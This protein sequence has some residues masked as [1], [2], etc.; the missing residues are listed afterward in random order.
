MNAP[1]DPLLV[2]ILG[3]TASSKTALA[4]ALA[5]QF[6][7]EIISCDSVSV[8]REANIGAAKP[9]AAERARIPHHM[10]DIASPAQRYTAGDYSRDARIAIREIAALNKLP[11]VS[12]GTGLYLRALLDGLFP[13]PQR[14]PALRERLKA[15]GES[16]DPAYIHR[17]LRRLDAQAA[18]SIHA[19]DTPKIIRAIEVSLTA[20]QP[21][22]EAWRQGRDPLTGFRILRIGLDP[23]RAQLYERINQRGA[24]M[25]A[26]GLV[27]ETSALISKYGEEIPVLSALG[28]KQARAFLRREIDE[29]ETIRQTQQG[30]RNYA[31]RQMSWFRREPGVHWLRG[32]GDDPKILAEAIFTTNLGAPGSRS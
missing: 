8:F 14:Q 13:G 22:T 21:I 1:H 11:I 19:N 16:R 18:A 27:A 10:L 26:R 6:N 17:I 15:R 20:R 4:L 31:K 12:G 5:E 25:F 30:H 24:E 23:D 9:T 32:F 7:G 3:P 2:V 28:Y 29:L